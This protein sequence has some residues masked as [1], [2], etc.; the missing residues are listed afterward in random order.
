M[1]MRQYIKILAVACVSLVA[2]L[3]S[4]DAHAQRIAVKTN[5]LTWGALT[6]NVGVEVV[7][8]ERTSIDLSFMGHINPYGM[9]SKMLSFQPEFRYWFNG[10]PMINQYVGVTVMATTYEMIL[11]ERMR[12]GNSL[13]LGLTGGYILALG[14]KFNIE[15][16]G[17]IGFAYFRQ[18]QYYM[19]TNEDYFL[20]VPE[21]SN[22]VGYKMLPVDLGITLTYII[23]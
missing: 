17:G 10:R 16:S 12:D 7:T 2:M 6:P 3:G 18:K 15:F 22:A 14:K 9:T 20:N 8:G 21:R 13:G 1:N 4:G 19:E 11:R 5:A 23:K